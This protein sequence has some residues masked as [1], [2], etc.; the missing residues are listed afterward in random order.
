MRLALWLGAAVLTILLTV[1][2]FLPAAWL[3]DIIEKQ[4]AGRLT[5]GDPQGSIWHGSAFIGGAPGKGDPVTPLLP[6]RFNW[7]LSPMV[8][9]GQVQ[10]RLENPAALSAPVQLSGSWSD[11]QVSASSITQPAE[12]LAGLGAPLNTI[13]PSGEM[14]LKWD[15]LNLQREGQRVDLRGKTT[16]ELNDMGSVVSS[17]KPLG[18]YQ[19]TMQWEGQQAQMELATVKGPLLLSGKGQLQGGQFQFS[20]NAQA[21]KGEEERLANLLN[22][23]GQRRNPSDKNIIALEFR[24]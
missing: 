2:F 18:S 19:L 23:L 8:L 11:W 6:G 22:L 15:T 5:L 14:R 20:G 9:L 1:L 13:K 7:Q 12:R 10:M 17:I 3:V 24:Q 16:L 4:T 21:A